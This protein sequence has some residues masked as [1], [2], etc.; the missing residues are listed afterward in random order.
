MAG[1]FDLIRRHFARA[2]PATTLGPGDDCALLTPSPG[3]TLAVT[4]DMLVAGVH[5]AP[6]ADP[7]GLGWKT[8]AVNVSDLAAMGAKPRWALLAG[9]LPNADDD[10]IGAFA[11]GFF[12]CA[13]RYQ[14][15]LVGGDT[16]RGPLTLSVTAI[17]ELP[18]GLALR[19]DG[20][21][22]GDDLW[23]SG[24]PG[25]AALALAARQGRTTLPATLRSACDTALDTPTPRVEL[26][27]ALREEHLAHAAID[28]SD[29]LLADLTHILVRSALAAEV[30]LGELAPA[31]EGVAS[32]LWHDCLLA[33]GDDYELLFTAP[34]AHRQ[35]I[36]ALA[37]RLAL[38]LTR[39][40][41]LHA[42]TP[43]A[44]SVRNR[45]GDPLTLTRRGYDHFG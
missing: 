9:A 44:L 23:I 15:D 40:G 39:C 31:P 5:F 13:A 19:R 7:E 21:R 45:N 36:A 14:L 37:K 29:G 34:S 42:G 38:P 8:L 27:L 28:V 35:A 1:E 11:R 43:G 24:T 20:A 33:G 6:D 17:G 41:R 4:T 26:G 22:E 25:L 2:T 3:Q 16:T 18:A 12:A 10:W 30:D 32:A